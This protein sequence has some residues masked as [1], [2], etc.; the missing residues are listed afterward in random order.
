MTFIHSG[1]IGRPSV[2]PKVN[3]DYFG[4][5]RHRSFVISGMN[6]T[7]FISTS[8]RYG[9]F[10]TATPNNSDRQFKSAYSLN[11]NDRTC[12]FDLFITSKNTSVPS[13]LRHPNHL[14]SA[15]YFNEFHSTMGSQTDQTP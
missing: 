6:I 3:A 11:F 15:Y 9:E 5:I 13:F 1:S 2:R 7:S 4:S 12:F 10:L 8:S 14:P